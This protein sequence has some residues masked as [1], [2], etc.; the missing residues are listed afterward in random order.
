M[1]TWVT[2]VTYALRTCAERRVEFATR[3][4]AMDEMNLSAVAI[5]NAIKMEKLRLTMLNTNLKEN[6]FLVIFIGK[7]SENV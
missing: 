1:L 3:K 2:Y 5:A 6:T 4:Q 7:P